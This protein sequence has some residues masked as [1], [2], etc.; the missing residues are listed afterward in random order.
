LNGLPDADPDQQPRLGHAHALRAALSAQH[1]FG[2]G[3]KLH[4]REPWTRAGPDCGPTPGHGGVSGR[5]P[6]YLANPDGVDLA[7]PYSL[8]ITYS[9]TIGRP[10]CGVVSWLFLRRNDRYLS[11]QIDRARRAKRVNEPHT[12]ASLAWRRNM[13]R[14][15]SRRTSAPRSTRPSAARS[16]RPAPERCHRSKPFRQACTGALPGRLES[17][18]DVDSGETLASYDGQIRHGQIQQF[19]RFAASRQL[20][21]A[22][23]MSP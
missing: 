3:A 5:A 12:P 17:V 13:R 9:A 15:Y 22:A 20:A 16:R 8:L 2:R 7:P 19:G 6:G 4:V 1:S 11:R 14:P 23:R 21:R 18:A 10:W